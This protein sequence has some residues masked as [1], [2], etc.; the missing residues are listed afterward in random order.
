MSREGV[1]IP[2][3]IAGDVKLPAVDV[4]TGRGFIT[5][6]SGAGKSSSASVIAEELLDRSF[7]LLIIDTDGEYWGLK[8]EYEILHVGADDE[9]DLQVGPEHAEKLAELALNDNVPIIL[10]V[11]G[12]LMEDESRELIQRTCSH[13]FSKERDHMQPFPIFVEEIH[14]YIPQNGAMD[15]TGQE[16]I[17]IGKRGRKRGLGIIGISQRPADVKKDFITQADWLVWHRLTWKNDTNVVRRVI[18]DDTIDGTHISDLDN[19]EAFLDADFL[20]SDPFKVQFRQKKT[21]DAGATPTLED[22][23]PPELKSIG[24]DLVEELE[25]ISDHQSQRESEL[26]QLENRLQQR[27]QRIDE[28][29]TQLKNARDQKELVEAIS[30]AIGKTGAGDG[31]RIDTIQAEVLEVRQ[32]K[33]ELEEDYQAVK[34]E[35]DKLAA[36]VAELESELGQRETDDALLALKEEFD[37]LIQRHNDILSIGDEDEDLRERLQRLEKENKRLRHKHESPPTGMELVDL[38][39]TNGVQTAVQTAKEESKHSSEHFDRALAILAAADG[40]SLSA[41]EIEPLTDVSA[42]TVRSVLRD[43]YRLGV[44][45]RQEDGRQKLYSLDRKLLESRFQVTR[46]INPT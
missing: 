27:E 10:D 43:L 12:F 23:E 2:I 24:N 34:Q 26:E 4:M 3:D 9:C 32:K 46:Q 21:F 36:R 29:E 16:L 30:K 35:R 39:E 11:S 22:F 17:R 14:E 42:A 28:L 1:T 37:E 45:R 15:E 25:E 38:L 20:S 5:G 44:L 31:S 40:R 8:E 19:G 7:P 41:R 33:R 6:K 18:G 13:L